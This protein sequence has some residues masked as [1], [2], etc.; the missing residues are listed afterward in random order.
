MLRYP[1]AHVVDVLQVGAWQQL[2]HP[3]G[4]EL[5]A[6]QPL[7][8]LHTSHVSTYPPMLVKPAEHVVPEHL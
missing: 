7:S 6:A 5:A 8:S 2:A 4:A 1:N 3:D